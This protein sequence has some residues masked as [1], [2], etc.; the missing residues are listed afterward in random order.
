MA[1]EVAVTVCI[2]VYNRSD[3]LRRTIDSVLGQ[4]FEHWE[5]ILVDDGS[6]DNTAEVCRE[7]DDSRV[8]YVRQENAGQ[9]VA[10]NRGLELARGKYIAFLD[11]DDV[12]LPDKLRQQVAFLD[13]NAACGLVYA[14]WQGC[15]DEGN[16]YGLGNVHEVSGWV[17]EH[18]LWKHNFVCTMSLPM[19]RTEL[20]REVGGFDPKTDISD[21]W[22]LFMRIALKAPFGF[23]PEVLLN[24]NIGT[25]GKQTN[26][27]FRVY[28]SERECIK[29]FSSEIGQLPKIARERLR[30]SW[31]DM[32]APL[33]RERALWLLRGGDYPNAWRHYAMLFR[34]DPRQFF[35]RALLMDV[36]ALAKYSLT[37]RGAVRRGT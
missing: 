33:F 9:A 10:R 20:V 15:D 21:D 7:Y 22:A 18:F 16:L 34:L 6:T 35:E 5:L 36:L 12:W 30:R 29:A 27:L 11:H 24:Y 8:Q 28:R 4:S 37:P 26:D 25:P 1:N 31:A 13:E 32:Y 14:R 23:I 19:I 2:P 3:A 17:Y